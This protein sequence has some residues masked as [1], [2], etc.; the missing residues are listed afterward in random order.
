MI[1]EQTG[2]HAAESANEEDL[3]LI[4]E[5]DEPLPPDTSPE[6]AADGQ[7]TEQPHEPAEQSVEFENEKSEVAP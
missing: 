7:L 6:A 5:D 4:D 1:D 3:D 2:P